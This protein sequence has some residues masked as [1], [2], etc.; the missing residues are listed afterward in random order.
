M[1]TKPI[2]TVEDISIESILNDIF[3]NMSIKKRKSDIISFYTQQLGVDLFNE[4]ITANGNTITVEDIKKRIDSLLK[5]DK[6]S[7]DPYLRYS[8]PYFRKA[9]KKSK[10]INPIST[11]DSNYTGRG[12]ECIVMGE[13]LFRGYNVN[14]M[15]V[16]EGIDLV[17]SKNNVFF[18]IQVKTKTVTQQN[19]FYFQIN[20]DRFDTFIGTQIRYI[21]VGRCSFNE[22]DRNIFFKFTNDDILRLQRNRVIPEPAVGS[23]TLSLKIEYDTR[24]GKPFM[25]DGKY[26]EDVSFYMNNFNL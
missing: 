14:S 26:K 10:P 23:N 13:L 21:L 11:V 8:S 16:D 6:E 12:G 7:I 3:T 1:D 4:T 15:M 18:Y 9:P 5:K 2:M 24:T 22:E 20:Q 17:A 25:Y 19:K